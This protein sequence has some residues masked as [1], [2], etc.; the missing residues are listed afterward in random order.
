MYFAVLAWKNKESKKTEKYLDLARELKMLWNMKVMMIR[1]PVV[2]LGRQNMDD[3]HIKPVKHR[4]KMTLC[5]ILL[6]RKG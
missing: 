5:H 4:L 2:S 6:E 3:K 1:K